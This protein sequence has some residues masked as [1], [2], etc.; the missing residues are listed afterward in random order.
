MISGLCCDMTGSMQRR[1]GI[2][3]VV[4]CHLVDTTTPAESAT[5][6]VVQMLV[7]VDAIIDSQHG[8]LIIYLWTD[9]V[10]LLIYVITGTEDGHLIMLVYLH[11]SM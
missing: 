2:T 3:V 1:C 6:S 4:S 8:T 9:C 11:T 5:G 7:R 10:V